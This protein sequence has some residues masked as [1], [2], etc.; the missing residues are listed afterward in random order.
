M[1]AGKIVDIASIDDAPEC[2]RLAYQ[3]FI[4]DYPNLQNFIV[5]KEYKRASALFH[6]T[7]TL[8]M[9]RN[10]GIAFTYEITAD[11]HSAENYLLKVFDA[12]D[13]EVD[14]ENTP[15]ALSRV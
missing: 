2:L 12:E 14:L 15:N 11:I 7:Y 10:D 13:V 1:G 5:I 9:T 6:S 3:R 8:I 4:E